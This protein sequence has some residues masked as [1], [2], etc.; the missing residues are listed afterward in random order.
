MTRS[1]PIP[2]LK[3]QL[4]TELAA[5]LEGWNAADVAARRLAPPQS[6]SV[7]FRMPAANAR[8]Y[9]T[10]DEFLTHAAA[11]GP[12]ELVRGEIRLMTPASGAHGVI[13]GTIFA[14]INAF[15]ESGQLGQCF[16]GN[17]G[18]LLPGLGDTV[19][20]PDTAFVRREQLP[21]G[22]IGSGWV[23]VAP[24][25]VVEILSPSETASELEEKVRDYRAAGTRLIWV[26]DPA[27]RIVSVRRTGGT[28]MRLTE[29][30]VL[31]GGDV[32]PGFTIPVT[33]L[34]ARLAK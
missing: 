28:D 7:G 23:S 15:V 29:I 5:L 24:D 31:D 19:R 21:D 34:F 33:R 1:D 22:G 13:A 25:L 8:R 6:P 3:C 2:A 32:L 14:A 18:F 20:S 16:P 10:S 4:G 30:D 17:T 9:V 27:T 11:A 26:I 12:S